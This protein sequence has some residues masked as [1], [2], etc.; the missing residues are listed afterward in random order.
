MHCEIDIEL[1]RHG[2]H[3][4]KEVLYVREKLFLGHVL[5]ELDVLCHLAESLGLPAGK[6]EVVG[7]LDHGG[8]DGFER[9]LDCLVMVI[10]HRCAAV[11]Q[12]LHEIAPVPV[13]DRHEVI[14][15]ALYACL[16][17]VLHRYDVVIDVHI[18]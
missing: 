4:I 14:A 1:L 18:S 8:S 13:H 12:G 16:G 9:Q 7:S 10:C 5:I 11:R 17:E 3:R 2:Y 15:D 6:A